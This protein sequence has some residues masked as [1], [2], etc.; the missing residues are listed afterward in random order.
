MAAITK[1]MRAR[2]TYRPCPAI[3]RGCKAAQQLFSSDRLECRHKNSR[4]E[5]IRQYKSDIKI[6]F[7]VKRGHLSA[8]RG[9]ISAA[10]DGQQRRSSHSIGRLAPTVAQNLGIAAERIHDCGRDE[11]DTR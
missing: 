7:G 1:A 11:F 3:A 9:R 10:N 4:G 6:R 2:P 5:A 8:N